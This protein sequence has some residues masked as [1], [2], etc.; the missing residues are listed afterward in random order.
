MT[1]I[2]LMTDDEI[3]QLNQGTIGTKIMTEVKAPT[4]TKKLSTKQKPTTPI[5]D[6]S[7]WQDLEDYQVDE[8]LNAS[9]ARGE[10]TRMLETIELG[11]GK[12]VQGDIARIRQRLSTFGK[13]SGRKFVAREDGEKG[14]VRIVRVTPKVDNDNVI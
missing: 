1:D 5:V 9:R 13:S 6:H 2:R 4:K 11:K 7:T 10:L 12:R 8:A 14:F 3:N